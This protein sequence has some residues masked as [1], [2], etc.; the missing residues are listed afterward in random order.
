MPVDLNSLRAQLEAERLHLVQALEQIEAGQISNDE[1]R[2][3][4]PFG[5]RD[6]GAV[7]TLEMEKRLALKKGIEEQLEEVDHTLNRI[8][9]GRYGYCENC[10]M[11]I[12]PARLEAMPTA[13]LCIKCKARPRAR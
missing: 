3:S 5:K 6:Q 13:S 12:A 9:E 1:K 8:K 10:G 2:E 7:E 4:T 11:P